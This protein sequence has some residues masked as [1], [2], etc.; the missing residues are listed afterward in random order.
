PSPVRAA[1]GSDVR[2]P[3]TFSVRERFEI[4]KFYLAWSLGGLR[5][6]EYVKGQNISQR[7][8][9]LFPEELS[10]GNCSL[11]LRQVA[12]PDGGRYT[13]T[14]IYTPDKEQKQLE[15]QVTAAPRVSIPRK[16]G[17]LNAASSFPCHV[18]GFYPW[19]VTVTWLRDGRVLTDATR[20]APQRNP[21]GT[22][23]LT[24]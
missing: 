16:A 24:L 9:A 5:V 2:L 20:P 6:A 11:L 8:S 18:W 10:R 3:C 12:V 17:V 4:S 21:D 1:L 7:G 14:V 13:C 23:N 15:L 22:F 19:D